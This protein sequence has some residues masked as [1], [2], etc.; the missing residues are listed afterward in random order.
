MTKI[1][2]KT[3]CPHCHETVYIDIDLLDDDGKTECP[4]CNETIN[5]EFEEETE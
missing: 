3:E 1:L 2:L 4:N 5:I